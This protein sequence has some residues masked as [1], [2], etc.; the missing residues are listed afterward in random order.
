M[1]TK[2]TAADVAANDDSGGRPTIGVD[3]P[4]DEGDSA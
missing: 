1:H 4:A 3:G 2:A